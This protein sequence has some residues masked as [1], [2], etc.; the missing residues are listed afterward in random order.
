[1]KKLLV[2]LDIDGVLNNNI[3]EL[4]VFEEMGYY[5]L[6]RNELSKDNL[7]NFKYL[8]NKL[9][10]KYIVEIILSSSWRW[11]PETLQA[12]INQLKEIGLTLAGTTDVEINTTL[13]RT[14]EIKN[15]LK[16]NRIYQDILIL[17]DILLDDDLKPFQIQT[18]LNEGLT[19]KLVEK[20]LHLLI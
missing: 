6:D 19:Q 2:Y 17:D 12:V 5:P 13:S 9:Q 7:E 10:T 20:A 18:N 3:W 15:H 1:M 11:Y 14:M 4:K 8:I 16:Q